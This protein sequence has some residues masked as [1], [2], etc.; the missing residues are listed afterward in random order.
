MRLVHQFCRKIRI[1]GCSA[2]S[3]EVETG[4]GY[5]VSNPKSIFFS[6]SPHSGAASYS[7]TDCFSEHFGI[8]VS[9][10]DEV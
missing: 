4:E 10:K 7:D 9:V 6:R 3:E 1:L 8:F 5:L 2:Q